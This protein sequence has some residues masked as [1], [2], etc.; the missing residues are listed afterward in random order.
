MVHPHV[1][2]QESLAIQHDADM[3]FLPLAFHSPIPEVLRTSAPGKMGEY[4]SSGRPI[5]VHAPQDSFLSWF[6]RQHRCGV[7][8]DSPDCGL[9]AD[10]VRDI[11]AGSGDLPEMILRARRIAD[12]EFDEVNQAK[13]FHSYIQSVIGSLQ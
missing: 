8:V 13:L 9:L 5:L 3:L 2:L 11:L 10:A 6:F 4:L 7:V 12:A 1:D